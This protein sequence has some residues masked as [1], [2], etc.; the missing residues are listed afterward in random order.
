MVWIKVLEFKQ[1]INSGIIWD[2]LATNWLQNRVRKP[3]T[4]EKIIK[5]INK[6]DTELAIFEINQMVN[7]E[8]FC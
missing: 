2:T 1:I 5:L 6:L 8:S 3:E 4:K 7:Y